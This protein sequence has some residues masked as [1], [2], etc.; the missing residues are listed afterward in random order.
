[1]IKNY[2]LIYSVWSSC[3]NDDNTL[4]SN[5]M[6]IGNYY[7]INIL[8]NESDLLTTQFKYENMYD[9]I[10]LSSIISVY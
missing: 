7:I 5:K 10:S 8:I 2:L 1:M 4:K 9:I 6:L 3:Y